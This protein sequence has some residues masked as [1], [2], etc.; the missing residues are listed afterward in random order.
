MWF[1]QLTY[2]FTKRLHNIKIKKKLNNMPYEETF[3]DQFIFI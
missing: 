2:F 3:L 1:L